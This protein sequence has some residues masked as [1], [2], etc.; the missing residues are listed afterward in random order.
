MAVRPL[1]GSERKAL[2]GARPVGKIDPK[3]RFEVSIF[4]KR[5]LS[6]ELGGHV[7][8]LARGERPARPMTREDFGRRFSAYPDYLSAIRKFAASCG[9][10][11]AREQAVR[12]TVV[13]SGTAEQFNKAFGVDLQ[14]FEVPGGPSYRGR[15][16]AIHLPEEL[17]GIVDAVL[18][19]D[20][21]PQAK[22]HFRLHPRSRAGAGPRDITGTFTPP[23]LAQLYSFPPAGGA[24]QTIAIIELG[25]GY[26]ADD[27]ATYFA[28]LSIQPPP[29]VVAVS[30]DGASNQ[31]TGDPNGPDGEVELDI[32]VAG[33]V[34]PAATIA[35]YFA[36]NT[37]AGFLDAVTTAV[38]DTTNQPSVVSISWGQAES[39]W[40][41]QAM[42]A[43]DQAFQDAAA[44]GVT[45][46]VASG[47][48]GSSDGVGDG[49]DHV[50]FPASSSFAL[51]CGGT[52]VQA[53]GG[54]ITSE[55]VWNSGATGGAT[56]G[57]VSAVFAL[58]SYQAGL[59]ATDASG[60]ATPLS[61][62]G[63][64][65]V[66]GDADPATG[67]VVRVDGSDTV[68]GGTSAVAPL[69]AGLIACINASRGTPVGLVQ[70]LLYPSGTA[71]NPITQGNNGDFS[72]SPGWN[73]CT[74]LGSPIGT[75]IAAVLGA[76]AG[77]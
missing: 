46:C 1:Q 72:A 50:D 5:Q 75:A 69:W 22:P 47:D 26:N 36:P 39:Q 70:P 30:V 32:E 15:V 63:V 2:A 52:S 28:G 34:A 73:A 56:G 14:R 74:G 20:N 24:G 48:N 77:S 29:K 40:T 57:G 13:L 67:Y 60:N 11:V 8:R 16:G 76:T 19:L 17:H 31:P 41:Q 54:R 35:V 6:D 27:V 42:A 43:M 71:F 64:P 61:N 51:G 10:T 45:V 44:L 49:A 12:R 66:S 68:I 23:Q 25:G 18:G 53:S 37:D 58:P 9:L 7:A 33:A 59:Q 4:L 65:D 21:R 55:T 3:E 62:R 38:H